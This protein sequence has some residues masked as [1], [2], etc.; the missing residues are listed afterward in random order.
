MYSISG[1]QV[2]YKNRILEKGVYLLK[3]KYES[4][5]VTFKKIISNQRSQ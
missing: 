4:G 5:A 3:R 1:M 2:D